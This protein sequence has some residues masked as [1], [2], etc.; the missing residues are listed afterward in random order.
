MVC[1]KLS[2]KELLSWNDHGDLSGVLD[3]VAGGGWADGS[4][5]RSIAVMFGE[6]LAK[7]Y[8][9]YEYPDAHFQIV[10][11]YMARILSFTTA[12][13]RRSLAVHLIGLLCMVELGLS[14]DEAGRIHAKVFPEKH[15]VPAFEPVPPMSDLT[16]AFIHS[17]R[18]IEEHT[19]RAGAWAEAVWRAWSPHHARI[20]ELMAGVRGGLAER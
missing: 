4:L 20:R 18:D 6:V 12:S 11:A 14:G 7:D 17:A 5:W 15:D 3:S 1:F 13:A 9:E 10:D 16:V 2:S 19:V 8:G